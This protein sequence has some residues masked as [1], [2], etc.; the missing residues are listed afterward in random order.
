MPVLR[1]HNVAI[2]T[3]DF[4]RA[5]NFYANVLCL[6]VLREPYEYKNQRTL[7]WFDG[8]SIQLELY[9]VKFKLSPTPYEP[10]G[11]GP[12]H[13]AFEVE[14]LDAVISWLRGHGISPIKPP[15]VPPSGDPRQ[16]RVVF[17]SGPDGEELQFREPQKPDGP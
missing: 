7:A 4:D 12:D 10:T 13:V 15:F 16:S 17:F 2:Q 14:D 8:G 1:I 9:S 11:V 3:G 5:Y 6:P